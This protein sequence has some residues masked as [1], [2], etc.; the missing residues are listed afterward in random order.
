MGKLESDLLSKI[1]RA[2]GVEK[3]PDSL[4]DLA[5]MADQLAGSEKFDRMVRSAESEQIV[6]RE[7]PR[8]VGEWINPPGE[9]A[10][11]PARGRQESVA[12]ERAQGTAPTAYRSAVKNARE[13]LEDG[14][15]D[16]MELAER[17]DVPEPPD[18][19]FG[20]ALPQDYPVF[21]KVKLRGSTEMDELNQQRA[22]RAE[23]LDQKYGKGNWTYDSDGAALPNWDARPYGTPGQPGPHGSMPGEGPFRDVPPYS[24]EEIAEWNSEE[25]QIA[26][27]LWDYLGDGDNAIESLGF[28][29]SDLEKYEALLRKYPRRSDGQTYPE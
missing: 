11:F 9:S 18:R 23:Y 20:V 24:P 29:V 8:N 1:M 5:E 28:S 12:N 26:Q 4:E 6:D 3:D 13:D 10:P 16:Q 17:L 15:H 2:I 22:I 27:D 7:M 21:P 25:Y 14:L 19:S